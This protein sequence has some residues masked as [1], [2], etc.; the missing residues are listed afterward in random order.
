MTKSTEK[1]ERYGIKMKDKRTRI[2]LVC[3]AASFMTYIVWGIWGEKYLYADGA[4]YFLTV[5]SRGGYMVYPEG[6][7]TCDIL[8]QFFAVTAYRLGCTSFPM[9]GLLFGFGQTFWPVLFYSLAIAIALRYKK[10]EYAELVFIFAS[11]SMIFTG[12]FLQLESVIGTAAYVLELILYLL[13]KDKKAVGSYMELGLMGIMFFLTIHLN[14]YFSFWGWVLVAVILYRVFLAK[15]KL[16]PVYLLAAGGQIAIALISKADI[17]ARGE[18]PDLWQTCLDIIMHKWYMLWIIL[19]LANIFLSFE[20]IKFKYKRRCARLA[21]LLLYSA[22]LLWFFIKTSEIAKESYLIRY[23]NL[24]WGV[25]FGI[26][27]IMMELRR[28]LF[29]LRNLTVLCCIIA[30]GFNLYNVKS[31]V[32][33]R[34]YNDQYI[35][36]ALINPGAGFVDKE[37]ATFQYSYYRSF[38]TVGFQHVCLQGLRGME[39]IDCIALGEWD[40]YEHKDISK[41][42]SLER[43]GIEYDYAAFEK[44]E[45]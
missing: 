32:E 13:H 20:K 37:N 23:T 1:T 45:N 41:C 5:A 33:Y 39:K 25:L 35:V 34:R 10:K 31:G 2:L 27:L 28:D 18:A 26:L 8:M 43:Y 42:A 14:E 40:P 3:C 44:S 36:F 17:A 12:F 22:T 6:R 16:H 7:R 15:D 4:N 19:V 24:G 21:E 30:I 29:K 9:M 11:V 38:W